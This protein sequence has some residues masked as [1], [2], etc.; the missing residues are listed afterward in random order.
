MKM[1]R[2]TIVL[3]ALLAW[4][5]TA[6]AGYFVMRAASADTPTSD[7]GQVVADNPTGTQVMTVYRFPTS[8]SELSAIIHAKFPKDA[9]SSVLVPTFTYHTPD[10]T[11]SGNVCVRFCVGAVKSGESLASIDLTSCGLAFTGTAIA[12]Q[13]V[14]TDIAT[15]GGLIPKHVGGAS[16]TATA[17]ANDCRGAELYIQMKRAASGS[18]SSGSTNNIDAEAVTIDYN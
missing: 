7:G 5:T 8:A 4:A 1:W 9:T 6:H 2:S 16:C 13:W 17:G 10:G 15:F 18:C 14:S 11:P 3:A 12:G